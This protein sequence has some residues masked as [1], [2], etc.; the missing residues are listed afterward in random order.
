MPCPRANFGSTV[1]SILSK[2]N[3]NHSCCFGPAAASRLPL[4]GNHPVLRVSGRPVWRRTKF[5]WPLSPASSVPEGP[6]FLRGF[7]R[8]SNPPD[9]KPSQR[10]SPILHTFRRSALSLVQ[11]RVPRRLVHCLTPGPPSDWICPSTL[12]AHLFSDCRRAL[13]ACF[14]SYAS[15][16]RLSTR[17]SYLRRGSPNGSERLMAISLASASLSGSSWPSDLFS[18][19]KCAS[20]D[21]HDSP[22]HSS[23]NYS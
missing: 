6:W 7:L 8:L 20:P 12:G 13:R 16:A 5:V 9:V 4:C 19:A 22:A 2:P 11:T 14:P 10:F 1:A 17:R 21:R 15:P 23:C 18:R 3:S